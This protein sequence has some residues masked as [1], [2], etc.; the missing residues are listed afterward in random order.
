[1]LSALVAGILQMNNVPS[2]IKY[3][4][5][6]DGSRLVPSHQVTISAADL[7]NLAAK[8][9]AQQGQEI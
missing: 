2:D 5:S 4:R 7:Q 9:A 8:H 6:E 1:M 3:T